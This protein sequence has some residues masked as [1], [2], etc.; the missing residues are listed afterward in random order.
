M[1]VSALG[2]VTRAHDRRPACRPKAG[3]A[4]LPTSFEQV[5]GEHF[6][7]V[8]RSVRR[9]GVADEQVDDVVQE[10]FLVVYQRLGSFEG[11][12][13]MR[14]WLFG[15]T[16]GLV[17]NHRR[18][19]RRKRAALPGASGP[20]EVEAL[21][22][23]R[24]VEPHARAE[25]AEAVRILYGILDELD[26]DRRAVFVMAELEQ[27]PVPEMAEALGVNINTVYSRLRAARRDV[28]EAVARVR[29]RD[30]WRMG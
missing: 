28:N 19:L 29:A 3:E 27:L 16:L 9:L 6:A 5:Y 23:R 2:M 15:I 7:F 8:W 13:S 24:E 30:G 22:D 17:R 11:R 20:V 18:A 26:D 1:M 21:R 10:V 14:T 25:K 4:I 12:S